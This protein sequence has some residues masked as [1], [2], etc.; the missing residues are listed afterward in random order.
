MKIKPLLKLGCLLVAA[1]LLPGCRG[2]EE[3]PKQPPPV[4]VSHP[5]PE[6][7]TAYLDLTG[8]VS[9]SLSVNLVA[10]VPG[11]LQSVK[12]VDGAFVKKGQLL[13]VIEPKPYEEQLKLNEAILLQ[14]KSEY[15]R[16]L[17]LVRQNATSVASV[18]KWRS[19]RDQAEAQV[20]LA[21]INLGYTHVTAPFDGLMGRHLVDPGNMVGATGDTKLGT[22]EQISP[23][24]VYF[25]IN[26]RDALRIRAALGAQ[27]RKARKEVGQAPV[28]VGLQNE[29]GYPHQGTLDFIN[30]GVATSSG[31]IQMRAVLTN[32]E[33]ALFPGL[34]ARVH[35]PLG[36]PKPM[37]VVP[38]LAIGND[39]EGD[40]VLVV[41]PANVVARRSV[42]KGPLVGSD[43]AIES[44]LTVEDRVVV[45]GILNARPGDKVTPESEAAP[46]NPAS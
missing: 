18:E 9:A 7:V 12:F 14:A 24:Y 8:T 4:T 19:Q 34:F 17:E 30:P 22:L 26:E 1:I 43:C 13:F 6:S 23:I 16:Q 10:R 38:N 42:V 40:Y 29:D 15:D 2:S 45:K 11:Y 35:I 41:G 20:A 33:R 3:T 21:R 37:L 44:G 25:N 46:A 32:R 28:F 31:T 27:G 39:Q 5:R 36:E